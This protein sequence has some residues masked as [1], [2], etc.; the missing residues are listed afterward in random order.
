MTFRPLSSASASGCTGGE[1]QASPRAPHSHVAR[2]T[3]TWETDTS[4]ST[5]GV[6]ITNCFNPF[7][8]VIWQFS[9]KYKLIYFLTPQS[10]Y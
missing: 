9:E 5:W 2:V 7:V 1:Q 6:D 10:H 4:Y 3:M 8:K